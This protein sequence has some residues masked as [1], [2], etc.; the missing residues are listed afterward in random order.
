M[1]TIFS[2]TLDRFLTPENI[3]NLVRN[4]SVLGILGLG[5]GLV[6]I[7]RGV[8]L[9]MVGIMAVS[10]S[11]SI[12]LAKNGLSFPMALLYGLLFSILAGLISGWIVAYVEISP[13]FATMAMGSIIYGVGNAYIV[14]QM[15]NPL[16]KNVDWFLFIGNGKI[17]GIPLSIWIFAASALAIHLL[18]KLTTLGRYFYAV[19]DNLE[20]ARISGIPVRPILVLQYGLSSIMAFLAGMVTAASVGNMNIRLFTG[21]TIYD[22]LLVVVLG[23]IGLSGG[24]GGVRNVLI[25]ALL[26]GLLL[27]G[28]TILD[29]TYT[30]QNLLKSSVLLGALIVDALINPR[31]EQ[32]SQQGDI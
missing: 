18:L 20:S 9:T 8:D 2:I 6:V 19:G 12:I 21:T 10:M 29:I 3:I 30:V 22:V 11:L 32:T 7:G 27:N 24:R 25:G 14:V 5:M 1:F 16:P 15:V 4:V 26:I 28:M 23:G 17:V 31:D 13:I